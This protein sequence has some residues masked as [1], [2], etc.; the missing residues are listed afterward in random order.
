M[1][2][3]KYVQQT[4]DDLIS[5]SQKLIEF[6]E[7][8]NQAIIKGKYK[9]ITEKIG[10]KYSIVNDY[11]K[12]RQHLECIF[13]GLKNQ[14]NPEE[15]T[16]IEQTIKEKKQKLIQL[17]NKM[18]RLAIKNQRRLMVIML[19]QESIIDV[20]VNT[21]ITEE[22]TQIGYNKTGNNEHDNKV[23]SCKYNELI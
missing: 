13:L 9:E 6:L 21:I 18:H 20:I 23:I 5:T 11:Q 1:Q 17:T 8:E 22:Q 7:Y 2:H 15:F 4:F 16:E 10:E 14:L 3:Q 12:A 19:A